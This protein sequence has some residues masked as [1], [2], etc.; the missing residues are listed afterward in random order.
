MRD[1]FFELTIQSKEFYLT[2][3]PI[4]DALISNH[5]RDL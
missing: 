1:Y 3:K 2:E 5:L 4:G